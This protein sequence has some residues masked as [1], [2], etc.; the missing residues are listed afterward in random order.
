MPNENPVIILPSSPIS[1]RR[2]VYCS[3]EYAGFDATIEIA[4]A[5]DPETS[6]GAERAQAERLLVSLA[7]ALAAALRN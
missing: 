7:E 5:V 4:D 1:A 3:F 6:P 2:N